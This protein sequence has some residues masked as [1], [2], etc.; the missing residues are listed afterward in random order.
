MSIK[1]SITISLGELKERNRK[2][3]SYLFQWFL[4]FDCFLHLLEQMFMQISFFKRHGIFVWQGLVKNRF[5]KSPSSSRIVQFGKKI[6]SWFEKPQKT[7]QMMSAGVKV[8][9]GDRIGHFLWDCCIS[10]WSVWQLILCNK[11]ASYCNRCIGIQQ[12]FK[13]RY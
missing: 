10:N 4:F 12:D 11:S 9:H 3:T 7:N 13:H 1:F 5:D 6:K 8:L 2:N